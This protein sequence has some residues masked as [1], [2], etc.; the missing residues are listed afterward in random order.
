[1]P[2]R[3]SLA[4]SC[5]HEDR[6]TCPSALL[7]LVVIKQIKNST[8]LRQVWHRLFASKNL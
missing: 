6:S 2:K 5:N 8:Q 7:V 4:G 1:L 3:K